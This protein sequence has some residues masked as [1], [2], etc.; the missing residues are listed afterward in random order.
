MYQKFLRT[1]QMNDLVRQFNVGIEKQQ[2]IKFITSIKD[3]V[4]DFGWHIWF[5]YFVKHPEDCLVPCQTSLIK[6]FYENN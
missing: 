6:F 5:E 4:A 2:P 3:I 1:Y